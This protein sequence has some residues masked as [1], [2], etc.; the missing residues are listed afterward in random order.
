MSLSTFEKSLK[1]YEAKEKF[2]R[3][4]V[5]KSLSILDK[6]A[7]DRVTRNGEAL[8]R[9]VTRP[10]EGEQTQVL[11]SHLALTDMRTCYFGGRP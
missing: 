1:S 9:Y 8:R 2:Y 11:T 5:D 10:Q 3:P 6:G 4:S 7:R